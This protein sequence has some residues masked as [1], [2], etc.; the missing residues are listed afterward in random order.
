MKESAAIN[1]LLEPVPGDQTEAVGSGTDRRALPEYSLADLLSFHDKEFVLNAYAVITNRQPD[2]EELAKALHELRSGG[3]TKTE[4]VEQLVDAHPGVLIEGVSS[5]MIR[6]VRRMPLIGY[7]LRLFRVIIRLPVLVQHQQQFESFIVGQQQCMVEDFNAVLGTRNSTVQVT[8]A[9]DS[10]E[11][12]TISD[13]IKTVMMMSD[14]LIELS[15][16][17][18]SVEDRL[19]D[20]DE[21][22]SNEVGELRS[23][24]TTL[25]EALRSHQE[26][27]TTA[28]QRVQQQLESSERQISVALT[29]LTNQLQAEQRQLEQIQSNYQSTAA[30]QRSFLVNEQRAIV[31]AERAAVDDLQAQ[32]DRASQENGTIIAELRAELRQLRAAIEDFQHAAFEK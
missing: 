13:T 15:N 32:L 10:E 30:A 9:G 17:F 28:I 20:L 19:R 29:S 21:R 18:A 23:T 7:C 26:Q 5:P 27:T 11:R 3:R 8:G 14:S 2:A 1:K 22:Q 4:V 25:T 12:Q 16:S 6:K 31:E 24:L